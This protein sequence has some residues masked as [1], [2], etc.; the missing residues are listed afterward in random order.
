VPGSIVALITCRSIFP[1]LV[2]LRS[3]KQAK[4]RRLTI[5]WLCF[6]LPVQKIQ[7]IGDRL[8]PVLAIPAN[9]T[10]H[11]NCR[12]TK[13]TIYPPGGDEEDLL[14]NFSVKSGGPITRDTD[15]IVF[16]GSV[17][18]ETKSARIETDL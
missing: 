12:L 3:G 18:D 2:G 8:T 5:S 4:N 13:N 14:M 17:A 11:S 15:Q 6:M 7:V 16:L 9:C 10:D 1:K